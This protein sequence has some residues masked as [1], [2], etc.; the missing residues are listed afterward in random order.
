MYPSAPHSCSS[1]HFKFTQTPPKL[2][3]NPTCGFS[4]SFRGKY[5]LIVS[6][7]VF[8]TAQISYFFLNG[9]PTLQ[10]AYRF[11]GS[12]SL[13]FIIFAPTESKIPLVST[14][15]CSYSPSIQG[16]SPVHPPTF[17]FDCSNLFNVALTD[18]TR[19]K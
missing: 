17:M 9:I 1:F 7:E 16:S 14:V 18:Q 19:P 8:V 6:G 12:I 2:R 10:G 5:L 15:R 4:L 13:F 3:F 11:G